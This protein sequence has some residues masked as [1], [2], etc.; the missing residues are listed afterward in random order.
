MRGVSLIEAHSNT[1]N[2]LNIF[3]I[4]TLTSLMFHNRPICICT[5]FFVVN[6]EK[7]SIFLVNLSLEFF[8]PQNYKVTV[9]KH[10]QWK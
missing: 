1:R 6:Y 10:Y 4:S 2:I 3:A 9:T 5:N 7:E 8:R